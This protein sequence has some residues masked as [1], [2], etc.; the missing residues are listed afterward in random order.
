MNPGVLHLTTDRYAEDV[1]P[2]L[3]KKF[4][5]MGSLAPHYVVGYSSFGSRRSNLTIEGSRFFLLPTSDIWVAQVVRY[6]WSSLT[7]TWKLVR[8]GEVQLLVSQSPAELLALLVVRSFA[9]LRGFSVRVVAQLQGDWDDVFPRVHPSVRYFRFLWRWLMRKAIGKSD[10]VRV[11]SGVLEERARSLGARAIFCFPTWTDLDSFLSRPFSEG[12]VDRRYD[13]VYAGVLTPVKGVDV[14]LRAVAILQGR[15]LVVRAVIAG[16]GPLLN[17]LQELAGSL[18]IADQID[19]AGHLDQESL[20]TTLDD[21]AMLVHPSHSEGLPR[22]VMEAMARSKPVV[23]TDVGGIREIIDHQ[24]EGFIVPP[25]SPSELAAA[26]EAVLG[27]PAGATRM[28]AKGRT[29]IETFQGTFKAAYAEMI[30]ALI[31]ELRDEITGQD[32]KEPEEPD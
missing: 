21:A 23:V 14:L 9:R 25:G 2:G 6:Y 31:A 11:V 10:A 29:R 1:E 30:G 17:E 19:W 26:I 16:E 22:V 12:G 18:S 28:G 27:D 4:A 20:I 7:I 32:K 13:L 5:F 8:S 3:R 15:G 24:I